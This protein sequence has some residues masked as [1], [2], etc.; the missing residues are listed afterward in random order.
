VLSFGATK[1]GAMA[2]EAVVFFDPDRATDFEFRRKRAAHL[3]SKMRFLSVQL[4]AYL[5]DGLW[6]QLAARANANARRLADAAGDLLLQPVEA[7][8]VFVRPGADGIAALRAQGFA[9]YDWGSTDSGEA[10]FVVSWDQPDG[11]VDALCTALEG[12]RSS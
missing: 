10:R 5:E 1:N 3:F 2:A 12:I 11:D 7:N 9:F 6:L 8:E 4:L